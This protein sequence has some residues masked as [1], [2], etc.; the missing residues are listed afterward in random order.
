VIVLLSAVILG[1]THRIHIPGFSDGE[2]S[3]AETT[4]RT[5][6][7][8][9][10]SHRTRDPRGLGAKGVRPG[11]SAEFFNGDL[12]VSVGSIRVAPGG[13]YAVHK[14]VFRSDRYHCSIPEVAV[15]DAYALVATSTTSYRVDLRTLNARHAGFVTYRTVGSSR[16][17]PPP[18]SCLFLFPKALP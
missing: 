4:P 10:T 13:G 11:S 6:S 15:G 7:T 17:G 8:A 14:L 9:P 3:P 18:G 16:S 1:A 12:I 2:G 5:G